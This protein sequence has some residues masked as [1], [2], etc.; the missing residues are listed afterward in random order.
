VSEDPKDPQEHPMVQ[1]A[2]AQERAAAANLEL[3]QQ[4][5]E[6]HQTVR[7]ASRYYAASLAAQVGFYKAGSGLLT[8]LQA[9][10]DA[11]ASLLRGWWG[12]PIGMFLL[13]LIAAILLATTGWGPSDITAFTTETT[14]AL[15]CGE[16]SAAGPSSSPPSPTPP[17]DGPQPLP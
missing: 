10:V 14:R 11:F 13:T 12:G 15:R 6:L 5:A 4:L 2:V 17:L 8:A 16:S 7:P 3:S 1:F 9:L